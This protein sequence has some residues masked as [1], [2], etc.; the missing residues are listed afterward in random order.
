MPGGTSGTVIETMD[1]G[2]Y[3]YV[4]VDT[5]SQKIWAA[6]PAFNISVGDEVIVP[7]GAPMSNFHSKT[8]DR[9][10]DLVYFVP[11][12]KIQGSTGARPE[13]QHPEIRQPM[14]GP[15]LDLS[16][17]ARAEGGKTV[18]EVFN[19]A[20]DLAGKEVAVRGKVIKFLPRIMGRNFLHLRDGTRSD[21]GD[22][23]LTVT[24]R[25][26]AEVGDLVT[27][28]GIVGVDKD[29]GF[30]Y[31]YQAIIEDATVTQE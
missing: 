3:T 16:G 6:A 1:S 14:P 13:S 20:A 12:V 9:T 8:L 23:D 31:R 21:A 4:H 10:F 5:G 19:E 25:D 27:V 7:R 17:I 18:A 22:D 24:T 28:R 30:N 29:F 11:G 26:S 2:G 15:A